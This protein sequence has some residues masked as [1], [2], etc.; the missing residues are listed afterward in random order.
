VIEGRQVDKWNDDPD[1]GWTRKTIAGLLG[2]GFE[3]GPS[4]IP[5]DLRS[6]VWSILEILTN[7][8]D[9]SPEDE[10]TVSE[11][12]D[13]SHVAINST[14]GE[15]M[16][17]VVRYALWVRGYLEKLPDGVTKIA[18]GFEEMPEVRQVLEAH[19]DLAHDPS[20]ALRSVYGRWLPSLT[21]L[22]AEWI[23][24]HVQVV[25]PHEERFR[26]YRDAAWDTYVV[27]CHPY[28]MLFDILEEEYGIAIE[29]SI[30]NQREYW[31]E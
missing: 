5:F 28:S 21:H 2:T 25:F 29:H 3:E 19:L 16:Q 14:R 11:P 9:P 8:L 7:D 24:N 18:R 20:L 15:A 27:L 1:W 23:K 4:M 30:E 17:V 12:I 26:R 6:Q 22:D 31:G 13:P 10:A